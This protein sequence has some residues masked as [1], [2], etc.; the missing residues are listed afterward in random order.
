MITQSIMTET[1]INGVQFRQMVINAG[2]S[3]KN[4][5]QTINDLNV[6]PVPDGDTGSNMSMTICSA[7]ND[8]MT[9]DIDTV[10]DAAALTASAMLRGAR[11]NSGVILSLLF[12]G[13]SKALRGVTVC[14]G[15]QWANALKAG[16]DA[17]YSAVSCPAEGTILTVARMAA[18][19]ALKASEEINSFEYV[20][21]AA[22]EASA[23]ALA[24]TV[25]QNPVLRKAGV[26][27]AGGMGWMLTLQAMLDAL[28]GNV[29]EGAL[30]GADNA[31]E[32]LRS[33]ESGAD[34]SDFDTENIVFTYCTEFI[35]NRKDDRDPTPLKNFLSELG[36]SLVFVADEEII[37]VHVHTN[38][39]GTAMQKALEYGDFISVKVE[40]MKRQHTS[41]LTEKPTASP[42]ASAAK[43]ETP[44][45]KETYAT[46][47]VCPGDGIA[48][49]FQSLGTAETISGGQ[50][51]NPS[52]DD[53]LKAIEAASAETVFVLPNNKNIIMAAE[54]AAKLSECRVV[55]IPTKSVPE[56]VAA[57]QRFDVNLSAEEI[58]EG[59]KEGAASAD[60]MSVTYAARDSEFDGLHIA[61]GD[62]LA[63]YDG[64]LSGSGSDL[65]ALLAT[66]AKK[67]KAKGKEMITIYYGDE[68]TEEDAEEAAAVFIRTFGDENVVL[69]P[70]GQPVYYYIISA[71]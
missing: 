34:F 31:E 29:Q 45:Y 17:A 68:V 25:N 12:R 24:E 35:V 46:V 40:N 14:D 47:A 54:Q 23:Q 59:M 70:G 50:T 2:A 1:G 44:R 57:M 69:V 58:A 18:E 15:M 21:D 66:L 56:G 65:A 64:K 55:V 9:S 3:I 39:P 33:P 20:M 51:M 16:V 7:V 52:T 19:N 10:G 30:D 62:Y 41:K 5:L 26:V 4:N 8:L 13:I 32:M 67:A 37:K 71:E 28:H 60:T 22:Y 36:D 6:F 48:E 63:L 27:D 43:K 11:G 38:E 61:C 42:S 49:V 53:I